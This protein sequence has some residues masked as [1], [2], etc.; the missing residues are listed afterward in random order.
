MRKCFMCHVEKPLEAF[1]GRQTSANGYDGRCKECAA[2]YSREWYARNRQRQKDRQK[3]WRELNAELH[4]AR[5]KAWADANRERKR[6][7]DRQRHAADPVAHRARSKAWN[8]ANPE[9]KAETSR[10]WRSENQDKRHANHQARRAMKKSAF[11]ERVYRSKLFARDQGLCGICGEA[12]DPSD[13]HVD[14]IVPIVHGGEHS[15]A[16]TQIAHPRCNIV[17]GD[18]I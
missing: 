17:K 18:R 2:A 7:A 12:V 15:Y 16:N 14:H 5:A 10:R 1:A 13:Y 11:V 8:D 6:E 9:R 3:S 4:R